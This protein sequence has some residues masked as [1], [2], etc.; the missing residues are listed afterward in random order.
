[1]LFHRKQNSSEIGLKLEHIKYITY[2]S[3]LMWSNFW[4][5]KETLTACVVRALVF[6]FCP[7]LPPTDDATRVITECSRESSQLMR[8]HVIES[9]WNIP[10]GVGCLAGGVAIVWCQG[11][12]DTIIGC[13]QKAWWNICS[14]IYYLHF[15][16]RSNNLLSFWYSFTIL[17][18]CHLPVK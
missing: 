17:E 1:M 18:V 8:S 9:W 13:Q 14:T 16:N 2:F 7:V 5:F 11:A 3:M 4:L 10:M 15:Y 12:P 6:M